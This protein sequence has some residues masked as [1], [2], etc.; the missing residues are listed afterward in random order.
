MCEVDAWVL[1][2]ACRDFA[3]MLRRCG[4]P[5]HLGVNGSAAFLLS[6]DFPDVVQSALAESG[7]PAEALVFE[8]T[9]QS[10]LAERSKALERLVWLHRIGMSI[11]IDDFGTGYNT[12]SY[13]KMYPIDIIKIDRSFVSD[14]E[15]YPYSRSV[16]SGILALAAELGL[17]VVAEG[18]ESKAQEAFL[19]SIGCSRLQGF[20]YGKPMPKED[21]IRLAIERSEQRAS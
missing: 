7:I 14:L 5:P 2:R 17:R 4:G 21:F 10:L 8:I 18:V 3:D 19:T 20:L 15:S 13:L 1:R 11:A 16:C 12:L 6:P 9:E